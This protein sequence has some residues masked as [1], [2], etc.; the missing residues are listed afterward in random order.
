MPN[1]LFYKSFFIIYCKLGNI[2]QAITSVDTCAIG[3]GFIKDEFAEIV[4]NRIEIQ[5]KH[6]IKEKSIQKF[7][8]RIARPMTYAIYHTL[9]GRNNIKRPPVLLIIS[10]E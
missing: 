3:F 6:L 1:N 4:Y 5:I 7:D 8:C 2:I 10:L 9:Y